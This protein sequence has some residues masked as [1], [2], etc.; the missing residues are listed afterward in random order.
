MSF[1]RITRSINSA[2]ARQQPTSQNHQHDVDDGTAE[3]AVEEADP[4]ALQRPPAS[5]IREVSPAVIYDIVHSPSYQVPVLYLTFQRLS[6]RGP[7][8]PEEVYELLVPASHKP[9]L[10]AVGVMG[11]LSMAE[12]PVTGLPAYFVHPCRTQEAM[13][14]VTGERTLRSWEYIVAWIGLVGPSV[15][16]HVPVELAKALSVQES[17]ERLAA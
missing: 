15:G 4:E 17:E 11:A 13:R 8:S 7:P 6:Q 12:H 2:S 14:S 16:L 1:L 10:Q 5:S 3:D 9:Q